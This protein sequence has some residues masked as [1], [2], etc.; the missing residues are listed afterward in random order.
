MPKTLSNVL[1]K[2]VRYGTML[3]LVLL[4][5]SMY[6]FGS[7]AYADSLINGLLSLISLLLTVI[8]AQ[9]YFRLRVDTGANRFYSLFLLA[10]AAMSFFLGL[11]SAV[12][13]LPGMAPVNFAVIT[14]EFLSSTAMGVLFLMYSFSQIALE[15]AQRQRLQRL[16]IVTLAISVLAILT[17][18]LT[19]LLFSVNGEGAITYPKTYFL[20]PMLHTLLGIVGVYLFYRYAPDRKT[21]RALTSYSLCMMVFTVLDM[22]PLFPNQ[23]VRL[24]NKI[25][26]A[27]V[28]SAYIIF[29]HLVLEQKLQSIRQQELLAQQSRDLA[30]LRMQMMISQIQPHFLYNTLSVIYQLCGRDAQMAR[31]MVRNFSTYL[32]TNMDSLKRTQPVPFAEELKHVNIFLDIEKQRFRDIL[33]VE[34]DI[35]CDDFTLPALSLQPLVENAVEHGIRSREEG[36]TVRISTYREP[37][38]IVI[39]VCDDGMGFDTKQAFSDGRSHVG[40]ENARTRLQMMCGGTLTIDSVPGQGTTAA[41]V[42]PDKPQTRREPQ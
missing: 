9:F 4:F 31:K 7:G 18:P 38:R 3:M 30:E 40:I 12:Q 10:Q 17:N 14:L 25:V 20:L 13:H 28:I 37:G 22:F 34:Y 35:S 41:I 39:A 5:G 2:A 6:L 36:G 27:P 33:N 15:E 16:L 24:D 32:R 42:I 26:F 8:L 11:S 19:G 29:F 23:A 1:S 21:F